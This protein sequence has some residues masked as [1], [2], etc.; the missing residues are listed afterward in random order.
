MVKIL[1]T[2][3]LIWAKNDLVTRANALAFG[4]LISFIPLLL[5]TVL[6]FSAF[7]P[8]L[9]SFISVSEKD[10]LQLLHGQ[11]SNILPIPSEDLANT[12]K[13]LKNQWGAKNHGKLL[14]LS[15]LVIILYA[16][17]A[18]W[19]ILKSFEMQHFS[20]SKDSRPYFFRRILSL[21]FTMFLLIMG[22]AIMLTILGMNIILPKSFLI[23]GFSL[24]LG[25][26]SIML[27]LL[28]Y[29]TL[30]VVYKFGNIEK[31]PFFSSGALFATISIG[32]ISMA[33]TPLLKKYSTYH[34]VYGPVTAI[35]LVSIWFQISS[36]AIFIGQDLNIAIKMIRLKKTTVPS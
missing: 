3:Q 16:S 15:F 20:T 24:W 35:L 30:C 14:S 6:S 36:F 32:L 18:M 2:L 10:F 31:I 25:A 21:Y 12:I 33:L 27:S 17:Q 28:L 22:G 34:L 5:L 8:H 26:K 4:L 7:A 23:M 19:L 9:P 1:K 13:F 11:L 29:L